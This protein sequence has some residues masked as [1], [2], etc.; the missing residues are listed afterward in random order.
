MFFITYIVTILTETALSV[1]LCVIKMGPELMKIAY[2]TR[3]LELTIKRY[4]ELE[5][6]YGAQMARL[7]A[8]RF[9]LIEAV[10]HLGEIPAGRPEMCSELSGKGKFAICTL[11]AS[12]PR[13]VFSPDQDS[14]SYNDDGTIERD[15]VTDICIQEIKNDRTE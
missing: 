11:P 3:Q 4:A 14:V 9:A 10:D 15:C 7:I 1:T 13:I 12:G 8:M 6:L 2:R 5:R